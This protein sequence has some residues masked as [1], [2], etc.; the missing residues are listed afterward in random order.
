MYKKD[1]K[2]KIVLCTTRLENDIST[3]KVHVKD[4]TQKWDEKTE[5]FASIERRKG[6]KLSADKALLY[7]FLVK[8]HDTLLTYDKSNTSVNTRGSSRYKL[9]F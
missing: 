1:G 8:K 6:E 9:K 4:I 5:E 7:K 3:G 2:T